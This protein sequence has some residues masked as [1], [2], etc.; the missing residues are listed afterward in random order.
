M[1]E[2]ELEMIYWDKYILGLMDFMYHTKVSK[3][4]RIKLQ[5]EISR[6]YEHKRGIAKQMA[7]YLKNQKPK[8][9]SKFQN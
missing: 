8:K 2:Y 6:V 9:I 1:Y 3:K 7:Q 5:N 4:D